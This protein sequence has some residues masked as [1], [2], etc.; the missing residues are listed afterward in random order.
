MSASSWN[1][2]AGSKG[3]AFSEKTAAV[4]HDWGH[5][6]TARIADRDDSRNRGGSGPKMGVSSALASGP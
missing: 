6:R 5:N 3:E 4:S 2:G 1:P